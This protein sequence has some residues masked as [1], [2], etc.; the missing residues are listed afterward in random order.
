MK[1][2]FLSLFLI[3]YTLLWAEKTVTI[4]NL[5]PRTDTNGQVV[6][7]HDGR[8]SQFNKVFYWYGTAYGATSGFETSNFYQCYSS[9]DLTN[10]KKEG[11]LIQN[12]PAGIYYRPHVIYHAKTKKYVLWYNWYPKLWEGKFGVAVSASPTGPFKIVNSDVKMFNS[13]EGLGDLNLF[14][15]EDG[16]AYLIYNTIKERQVSV[17]KLSADYLSSTLENGGMLAE[18]CE[19]SAMFKRN[20]KYYLLTDKSCRFCTQGAGVRVYVSDRPLSGYVQRSNINRFPGT[21]A[22][23]LLDGVLSPNLYTR[24]RK[25]TEGDFT[26]IQIEL[27]GDSII[28]TIKVIQFTGNRKGG[29]KDSFAPQTNEPIFT[30]SFEVY[31][32]KN[33][34]WIPLKVSEKAMSSSVYTLQDI[35]FDPIKT[36]RLRIVTKKSFPTD[37]FVNE[38]EVSENNQLVSSGAQAFLIDQDPEKYSPQIPG[39][40][41]SIMPLGT[42]DGIRFIW[43]ADLWGSA[44]DNIKG[45]DYQY[46]GAPLEFDPKGD[47]EP[48]KWV[49]TWRVK[50]P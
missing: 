17:E 1:I 19:A 12:P 14:T 34:Y 42:V 3:F 44:S 28:N 27:Q 25:H 7:A 36:R 33:G 49:D 32:W 35:R 16:T 43:M 26:P 8:I 11:S 31:Y 13:A 4:S 47:I 10:W 50:L 23:M 48:M 20:G 5:R 39:Q 6:D 15:D 29:T 30:P 2:R 41:A 46:W 45:H 9:T 38:I 24:V 22:S 37:L 40:Q 21:P 18:D